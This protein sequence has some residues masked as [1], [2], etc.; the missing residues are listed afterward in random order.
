MYEPRPDEDFGPDPLGR[1]PGDLLWTDDSYGFGATLPGIKAD[2]LGAGALREW[3]AQYQQNP[4]PDEG[5]VFK[6][7]NFGFIDAHEIPAGTTWVRAW[8]FADTEETG[9]NDPDRTASVKMG[10]APGNRLI[11]AEATARTGGPDAVDDMIKQTSEQDGR[12]VKIGLPQDPGS[13][14]KNYAIYQTRR[15]IGFRVEVSRESGSKGTR[16]APFAAQVNAAAGNVALVRGNWNAPFIAELKAFPSGRYDDQ[17]DA[18]SRA[19]MMLNSNTL[20][21]W[22]RAAGIR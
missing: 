12:G 22:R 6:T 11:I 3:S 21:I 10:L 8:D 17:V 16:A 5:A 18:A 2:L 13:A 9:T 19:F 4:T 14:G 20:E 1:A 15:L 7:G